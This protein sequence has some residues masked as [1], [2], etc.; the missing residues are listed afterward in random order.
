[1]TLHESFIIWL[2]PKSQIFVQNA[3]SEDGIL[4]DEPS[5]R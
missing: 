1:M 5:H 3:G 2:R 4:L